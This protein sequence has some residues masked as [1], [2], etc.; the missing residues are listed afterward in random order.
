MNL[1][2]VQIIKRNKDLSGEGRQEAIQLLEK[3]E[4]KRGFPCARKHGFINNVK[5]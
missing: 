1:L 4:L 2:K 3:I 5:T